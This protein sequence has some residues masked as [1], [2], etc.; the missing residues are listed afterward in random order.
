MLMISFT[1]FKTTDDFQL[2]KNKNLT[3]KP[4][5]SHDQPAITLQTYIGLLYYQPLFQPPLP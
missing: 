1:F 3:I 5:D 4:K 2:L